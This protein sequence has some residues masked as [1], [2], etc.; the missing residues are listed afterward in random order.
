MSEIDCP[1]CEGTGVSALRRSIMAPPGHVIVVRDLS[2]IEARV[3]A[4]LTEQDD[5]VEEFRRGDDVYCNM[6]STIFSHPVTKKDKVKRFIGKTTIL[7]CIAEGQK[8]KTDRGLVPIEAVR[9]S[10]FIWD[11]FAYVGHNGVKF[12]GW[13]HCL[14]SGG[15]IATPDHLVRW[16]NEMLPWE[17]VIKKRDPFCY[18]SIRPT[19]DIVDCGPLHQFECN[20]WVV[21]NCGYGLGWR[22]YQGRLRVGMLG[23]KGRILDDVVAASL[24]VQVENWMAK[25][26]IRKYVEESLPIGMDLITHAIHCACAE[27]IITLFRSNKPNIPAFWD[28]CNEALAYIY[29]GE[30]FRFGKNGL[31]VT[32]SKGIQFPNGCWM[33]YPELEQAQK[34]RGFDYSFLKNRKKH[35]RVKVYGGSVTENVD[36]GLSRI[37]I[38]DAMLKLH[39]EGLKVAHQVHDE[40]LCVCRED[41]ASDVYRRM[42]EI[43]DKPPAWCSDLPVASD[44]G[45][46][47]RYQK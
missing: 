42:G 27:S 7:G 31:L 25:P 44:G 21:H 6:A 15:L 2:Q 10:D 14:E 23:D 26:Y 22:T 19:Y 34:K 17:T 46:N 41:E 24:G 18:H 36:Q 16:K 38:T 28:T 45:W 20:G 43:M 4:W 12:S 32:G 8:I 39:S 35:E 29:A 11:G 1:K 47:R 30:Q 3:L 40:I 37:I 5:L 9:M 33:Q 13:K